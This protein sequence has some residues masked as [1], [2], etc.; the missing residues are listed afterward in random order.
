MTSRMKGLKIF[1]APPET[2]HTQM[3]TVWKFG[4]IQ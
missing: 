4:N 2:V 3:A 1:N